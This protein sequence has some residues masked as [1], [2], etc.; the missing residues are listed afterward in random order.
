VVILLGFFAKER[1]E[2]VLGSR[3][4]HR[5]SLRRITMLLCHLTVVK[6]A[7]AIN[8]LCGGQG[9]LELEAIVALRYRL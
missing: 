3:R 5:D 1:F 6:V 2:F 7:A 9:F 8:G 4:L